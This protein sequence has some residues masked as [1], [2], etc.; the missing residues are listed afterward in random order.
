MC[1]RA[2]ADSDFTCCE[3]VRD[4]CVAAG[5]SVKASRRDT[6]VCRCVWWI[7]SRGGSV[8]FSS[9]KNA[10]VGFDAGAVGVKRQ[11][12]VFSISFGPACPSPPLGPNHHPGHPR[13]RAIKV[14]SRAL[15]SPVRPSLKGG[16]LW[17]D[18]RFAWRQVL[19]D[20]GQLSGLERSLGAGTFQVHSL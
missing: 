7:M 19:S 9:C 12:R 1:D 3:T 20:A 11:R 13:G 15:G 10:D 2:T 16:K 17:R 8:L 5:F 14:F 18:R 6:H 4:L